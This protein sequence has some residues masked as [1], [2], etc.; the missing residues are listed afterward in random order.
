LAGYADR[1]HGL[2]LRFIVVDL[3][4][5]T[6]VG[7]TFLRFLATLREDHPESE[8]VLQS[9]PT[10]ARIVLVSTGME[11]HVVMS[12]HPV[13]P[14]GFPDNAAV[15]IVQLNAGYTGRDA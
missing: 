4:A 13:S 7:S 9:P 8:L 3:T 2:I 6:Y 1:L 5:V 12:G 11:R 10:V 15:T 14:M